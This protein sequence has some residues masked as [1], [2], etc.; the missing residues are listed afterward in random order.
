[1]RQYG[2]GLLLVGLGTLFLLQSLGVATGFSFW[3]VVAVLGGLTIAGDGLSRRRPDLFNLALG[4]WL[5]AIGA[6]SI[7][8]RSGVTTVTGGDIAGKGWPLLLVALGL[9]MLVGRGVKVHT[10]S[11]RRRMESHMVGDLS[12]GRDPWSLEGDITLHTFVGDLK[13]DLTTAVIAPGTHRIEVSQGIGDTVVKVP[14]TVTVRARA[15]ANIGTVEVLGEERGGV[16]FI[17]LERE[18]YV[19]GSHADLIIDASVR[20]GSVTIERVPT[21]DFEVF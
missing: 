11:T 6:F 10:G 4:L 7:L 15:G 2:W 12:Y 8:S 17:H 13:I 1:M 20:I 18:A 14:D 19:P 3:S 21:S 5:A 16:G 9:S